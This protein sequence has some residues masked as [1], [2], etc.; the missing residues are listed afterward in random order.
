MNKFMSILSDNTSEALKRRADLISQ[1][2]EIAQTNLI[3]KLKQDKLELENK[4]ISLTDMSPQTTDSL[5]PNS[6][7]FDAKT[8]VIE[9]QKT[10]QEL[11]N[12]NIQIK[13]A[14]ETFDEF[15]TEKEEKEEQFE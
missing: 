14:Q 1:N 2:A 15:F 9:M 12:I 7:N 8:W 6:G 11:H 3:N 10:K 13:L 5:T 4:V